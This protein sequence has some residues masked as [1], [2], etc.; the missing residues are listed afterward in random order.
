MPKLITLLARVVFPLLL[1]AVLYGPASTLMGFPLLRNYL[2][3]TLWAFSF[4]SA[5]LI[6]WEGKVHLVWLCVLAGMFIIFELAQAVHVFGGTG[7]LRDTLC[8]FLA[9]AAAII[10]FK[11][12]TY[13]QFKY[14]TQ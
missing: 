11:F 14:E 3:D 12:S 13:Y 8:Y 7:D 6:I 4:T 2:P 10:S 5:L 1:G 9:G